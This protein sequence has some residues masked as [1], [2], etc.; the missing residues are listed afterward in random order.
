[1]VTARAT[2]AVIGTSPSTRPAPCP[3]CA[4]A[5]AGDE[6]VPPVRAGRDDDGPH[7]GPLKAKG[8]PFGVALSSRRAANFGPRRK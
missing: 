6:A 8:R 2:P 1:M 4:N 5:P 3:A 7:A